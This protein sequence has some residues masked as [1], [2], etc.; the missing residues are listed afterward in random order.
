[1]ASIPQCSSLYC[2]AMA[3]SRIDEEDTAGR[4]SYSAVQRFVTRS[5]LTVVLTASLTLIVAGAAKL[6]AAWLLLHI[7]VAPGLLRGLDALITGILVAYVV[8]GV[9]G[10]ERARQREKVKQFQIV[11]E[12]NH[13]V[14]NALDVIV[15]SEYLGTGKTTAVLESVE[16]I[17]DAL[18]AITVPQDSTQNCGKSRN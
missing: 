7:R 8:S 4:L 5:R 6:G 17:E 2:P 13:H 10:A 1:M 11:A 15:C 9:L 12:L 16:R 3:A 14:R 18:N